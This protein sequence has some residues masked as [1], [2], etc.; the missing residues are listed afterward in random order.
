LFQ[1]LSVTE[2]YFCI[3]FVNN[4]KDAD[5]IYKSMMEKNFNVGLLHKDLTTRERKKTYKAVSDV[6]YKYLV[7]TDLSS[8]GIDVKGADTVISYGLPDEDI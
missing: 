4:K 1:F 2:T 3:I 7:S 6:Q 5:F 8:R